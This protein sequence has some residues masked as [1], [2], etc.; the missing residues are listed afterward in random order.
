M[1]I[2]NIEAPTKDR[3]VVFKIYQTKE[4]IIQL[5]LIYKVEVI[6]IIDNKIRININKDKI[7]VIIKITIG[8]INRIRIIINEESN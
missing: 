4:K 6:V 8:L 2:E 5:N 3:E 7:K 1:I